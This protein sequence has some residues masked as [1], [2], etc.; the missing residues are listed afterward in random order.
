M[1]IVIKTNHN[2]TIGLWLNSKEVNDII[3]AIKSKNCIQSVILNNG[4]ELCFNMVSIVA[5]LTIT[6][7]ATKN[8]RKV[9]DGEIDISDLYN[10][11]NK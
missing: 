11:L 9:F 5:E 3:K 7:N 1:K 2:M 8:Y 4:M 10:Q 6:A